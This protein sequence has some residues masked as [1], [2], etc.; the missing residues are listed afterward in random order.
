MGLELWVLRQVGRRGGHHK[1][2]AIGAARLAMS[3]V[4]TVATL[5]PMLVTFSQLNEWVK[6]V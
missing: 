6:E 1:C 2:H 3:Y 5:F 4:G